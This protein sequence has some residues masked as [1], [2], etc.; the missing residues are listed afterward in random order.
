MTN[1]AACINFLKNALATMFGFRL[2]VS[3]GVYLRLGFLLAAIKYLG[4][5]GLYYAATGKWFSIGQFLSPLASERLPDA[6]AGGDMATVLIPLCGVLW[7]L[8]FI[9]VGLSMSMRRSIDAGRSPWWGLLFFVPFVNL[10]MIA[11]IGCLPTAALSSAPVAPAR[12]ELPAHRIIFAFLW[13]LPLCIGILLFVAGLATLAE[14]YGA[15]LFMLAPFLLGLLPGYYFRSRYGLSARQVILY[16]VVAQIGLFGAI[17]LLALEGVICLVMAAPLSLGLS[18][19]GIFCGKLLADLGASKAPPALLM[20]LPIVPLGEYHLQK[21][22]QS[23]VTSSV[24]IE[25]PIETVWQ[26]VVSFSE[27]PKPEEWLFRLGIAAP[28]RARI[29]GHGVGAVR[30]CEFTTGAFVEPITDWDEPTHLG[31]DVAAQPQP[32]RELS[33][34][35]FVNAPHLNGFFQSKKGAFDLKPLGPNRTALSGTTWYQIDIHPGWYWQ[36]YG[37]WFVRTIHGRVLQHISALSSK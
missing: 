27:M 7:A 32:M 9:W 14:F 37:H 10:L 12:H 8:P 29:E 21:P 6:T 28:M 30:Y 26:N 19:L 36:L 11:V 1:Q 3:R 16:V 34:Y 24:I 18:V 25:A 20:I 15:S 22:H 2:G 23:Y 33:F 17:L 35:D 4:D 31:F 5:A 13:M